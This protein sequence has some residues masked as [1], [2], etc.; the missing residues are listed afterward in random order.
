MVFGGNHSGLELGSEKWYFFASCSAKHSVKESEW[1]KERE[2]GGGKSAL[3]KG[4][5]YIYD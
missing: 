3:V 2:I 5:V 1:G 4:G